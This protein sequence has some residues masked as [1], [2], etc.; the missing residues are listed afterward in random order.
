MLRAGAAAG[1]ATPAAQEAL[2]A[3][4]FPDALREFEA[5]VKLFPLPAQAHVC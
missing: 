5:A 4:K 3:M 1:T 2:K